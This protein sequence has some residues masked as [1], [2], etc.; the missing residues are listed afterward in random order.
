M[1]GQTYLLYLSYNA[2]AIHQDLM[3]NEATPE[4]NNQFW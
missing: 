4:V 2:T 1:T 3:I